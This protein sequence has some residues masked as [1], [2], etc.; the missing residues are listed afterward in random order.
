[1]KAYKGN[2]STAPLDESGYLHHPPPH[3]YFT[4]R[5]EPWYPMKKRLNGPHSWS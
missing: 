1:M 2:G 5:K 3:H 4:P